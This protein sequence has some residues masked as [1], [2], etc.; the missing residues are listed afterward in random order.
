M[1]IF[2]SYVSLPEGISTMTQ[3]IPALRKPPTVE[4]RDCPQ[5]L[6]FPALATAKAEREEAAAAR[7]HARDYAMQEADGR[8]EDLI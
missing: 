3:H 2:N 8:R 4:S 6:L 5:E 7:S 1:V